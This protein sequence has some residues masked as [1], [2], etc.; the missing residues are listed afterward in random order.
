MNTFAKIIATSFGF[1]YAPVAPGTFG[2]IFGC[3]IIA[4]LFLIT[5]SPI[6]ISTDPNIILIS[7]ILFFTLLGIWATN[8]LEKE[9]G[10]DP[11]KI[12]MDETVG[13]WISCLFIPLT[14][15]HLIAAFILF[16]FFDILKPLGIKYFE[17][18]KGG[19]GV[20]F[21]DV[22][23]GIYANIV[24]QLFIYFGFFELLF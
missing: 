20:M 3:L 19:Y 13:I 7:A 5:D 22:V 1:G 14:W 9:W 4:I 17:K 8:T 2:A 23:A 12:V 10:H 11:G 21:D 18:L 15:T 24:L 16:R 6:F